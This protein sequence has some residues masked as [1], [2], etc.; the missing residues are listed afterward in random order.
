[1][2]SEASSHLCRNLLA[3]AAGDYPRPIARSAFTIDPEKN[4]SR[5]LSS[6]QHE[7]AFIGTRPPST[8]PTI[9][10]GYPQ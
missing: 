3:T 6:K 1:M 10:W 9:A 8:R 2:D 4:H 5:K 7:L